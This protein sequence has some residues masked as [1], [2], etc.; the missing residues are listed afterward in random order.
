MKTASTLNQTIGVFSETYRHLQRARLPSAD[1]AQIKED[2]VQQILAT[3]K[4]EVEIKGTPTD[5]R[6]VLFL[7]NH[8]SY[9]DIPL[10][11]NCLPEISFVAKQE[12]SGWPL[13]GEAARQMETVFV[14]REST[15]SRKSARIA[16]QDALSQGKRVVIFPSGTT[17]LDEKK[18]WRRGAFEIAVAA[19]ALVQPFRITYNPLRAVAYID[20]DILPL[21]LYNLVG[22]KKIEACVEFHE[23]V[24]I[25]DVAMDS[26]YW[27]YWSQ[28]IIA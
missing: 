26:L 13:F 18:P 6:S 8:I 14:K 9:L 22:K 4:V 1:V 25:T 27:Q 12:I 24:K 17:C 7:G 21:H 5:A 23:P 19:E 11:M 28:G 3:L 20:R 2:W 10:L 15:G 16:V